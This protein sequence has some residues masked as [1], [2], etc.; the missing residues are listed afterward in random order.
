MMLSGL[1]EAVTLGAMVAAL[2]W[3]VLRFRLP[4]TALTGPFLAVLLAALASTVQT[5]DSGGSLARVVVL[6]GAVAAFYVAREYPDAAALAARIAGYAMLAAVAVEVCTGA[7]RPGGLLHNPNSAASALLLVGWALG[8]VYLGAVGVLSRGALVASLAAELW[9]RVAR[10]WVLVLVLVLAA[11]LVLL[12][13]ETVT[14]RLGTWQ[15]AAG[16]F[17]ARPVLGWGPGAYRSLARVEPG[18]VHADSLPLT[19]AAEGGLVGL[20]A[21]GW[22]AVVV[23][24][25]ARAESIQARGLLAWGLHQAVDCTAVFPVVL[26]LLAISVAGVTDESEFRTE[27]YRKWA[28]GTAAGAVAVADG[29]SPRVCTAGTVRPQ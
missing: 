19:V 21:W 16:L 15:E 28:A 27:A 13:P 10:R 3:V 26:V 22:L 29:D 20:A 23:V 12:R 17:L 2:V 4:K 25:R 24:K 9:G 11:G 18:H 14:A 6:A 8:P 7:A 5:V 1:V